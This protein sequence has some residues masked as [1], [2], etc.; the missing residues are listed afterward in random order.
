MQNF[1]KMDCS[2]ST[3]S[4]K[5]LP[6]IS[7]LLRGQIQIYGHILEMLSA[8]LRKFSLYSVR[9]CRV[10]F[11]GDLVILTLHFT[12]SSMFMTIAF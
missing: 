4:V 7:K 11:K 8:S 1:V 10:T 2:H 9:V 5:S 6:R 3:G 12:F